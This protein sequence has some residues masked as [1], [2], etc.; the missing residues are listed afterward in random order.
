MGA[1]KILRSKNNQSIEI[2]MELTVNGIK[3]HYEVFGKGK[4]FLILH[5]WG[6]NSER[7]MEVAK[8]ISEKGY[9]VIVP[10]L[11]GF[12]KSEML[13]NPWT[14]NQYVNWTDAFILEL[15]LGEFY[16][17]GHSFGGALAS[18]MAIKHAQDMKGLF[19]VAAAVVRTKTT[20][21]KAS[22]GVAKLV[23]IFSFMPGYKLFRKAVYKFILRRSDYAY[24]DGVMKQT[25]LNVIGDDVSFQMPFIKVPTVVIW[26]DKDQS[27]PFTEGQFIQKEIKNAILEVIPGAGHDLNR[28]QPSELAEKVLAHLS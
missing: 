8:L 3:T 17:L 9:K 24:V 20:G 11:P 27:T 14:A 16:L 22:A 7:W 6:S 21:K 2:F 10:D 18:K 19:L 25:Y 1:E 12:G 15:K 13:K 4:P 28:K 26:G 5:G 23:G